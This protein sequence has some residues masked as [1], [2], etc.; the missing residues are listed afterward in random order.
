MIER[1]AGD[2]L[3]RQF[4]PGITDDVT[5]RPCSRDGEQVEK[6]REQVRREKEDME[7]KGKRAAVVDE[8]H[9]IPIRR[10]KRE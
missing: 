8:Q 7:K 1:L 5:V 3:T 9:A 6:W 2:V 10:V 4:V